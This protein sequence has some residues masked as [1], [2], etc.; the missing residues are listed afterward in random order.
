MPLS[1]NQVEHIAKLARLELST[2]EIE[3]FTTELTVI[4]DY[5]DQ[6]TEVNTEG[7]TPYVGVLGSENRFREDLVIPS[8]PREEALKNAPDSDGKFFRVPKVIG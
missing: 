3:Q 7:V 8:L 5:V 1:T 6:L 4:L 2:Q